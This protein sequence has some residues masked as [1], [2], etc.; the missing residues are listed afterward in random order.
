MDRKAVLESIKEV[1]R[2]AFFAAVAAA[3][4]WVTTKLST[5]DPSSTWVIVGT[6]VLRLVDK[7]IH[8]SPNTK[9]TG[10]SPV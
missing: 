5:L 7:Y 9:L 10:I 3:V 8:V 4:A 6:V 2:L 1:L